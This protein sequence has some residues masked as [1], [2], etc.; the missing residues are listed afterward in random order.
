MPLE[1][2]D[3]GETCRCVETSPASDAFDG[4]F[5]WRSDCPYLNDAEKRAVRVCYGE[6]D[7]ALRKWREAHPHA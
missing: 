3:R 4:I 5:H 2:F 7:E 1:N 6:P